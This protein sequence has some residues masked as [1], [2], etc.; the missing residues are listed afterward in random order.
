MHKIYYDQGCKACY[1]DYNVNSEGRYVFVTALAFKAVKFCWTGENC[2]ILNIPTD[3]FNSR[4]FELHKNILEHDGEFTLPYL[5]NYVSSY[6]DLETRA[7]QDDGM[8]YN[9]IINSLSSDRLV[10][11]Y[12][13]SDD[14]Y[15]GEYESGIL[16]LKVIIE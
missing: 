11:T 7:A 9:C 15:V 5:V 8:M 12:N 2:G 6:V 16:L 10:K 13:C 14:Y 3:E 1:G 4:G